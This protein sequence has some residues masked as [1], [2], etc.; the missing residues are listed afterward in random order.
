MIIVTGGAGFI[1]SALLAELNRR[2]RSDVIVVDK[3]DHDIEK[4]HNIGALQ[5]EQLL[6]GSDFREQLGSGFF[7]D[8]GIE[9]IIH[10]AAITSTT[11]RDWSLFEDVNIAFSQEII[12]WCV[13]K[14]VRCVYI[15][16]GATYGDGSNGYSDEHELFDKL[17]PLNDYGRS[18]LEV[19]VWARDAG[20]LGEIVGIR[21]FN[22][23]GP[24]EYHKGAMRSVIAKKF[25]QIQEQGY[26]ELFKSNNPDYKDGEQ[27]RDFIYVTDAV[28]ATLHFLEASS[29]NGVFNVGTG[30]AR[31]WNDVAKAMFKAMDKKEDI[32]YV[33]MPA[34]LKDQYQDFTQ[35][36]ISKL[37][38][39]GFKQEFMRLEDAIEDYIK[40]YLQDHEH[41]RVN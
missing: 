5:Y 30:K 11:E 31:A 17:Q 8:K 40:N 4:K 35:A 41:V 2:G 36:D 33:D 32:R 19:D 37:R 9:A 20:Y 28:A 39:A 16:S 6:E 22:V 25:E 27:M 3:I 34:N 14:G 10:L 18:K 23:Y 24:N 15:S 21:Y 26:I 1:G 13:D 29:A 38:K 12:R 7:N